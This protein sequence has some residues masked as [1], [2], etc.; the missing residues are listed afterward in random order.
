[1][2]ARANGI[3]LNLNSMFLLVF[4]LRYT[5]TFLRKM[6][7]IY[8]LP[9]DQH[10]YFHKFAGILIFVQGWFHGIMH[11]INFGIKSLLCTY[12]NIDCTTFCKVFL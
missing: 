10:L 9:L 11:F 5:I 12:Y 7:L 6:G 3:V 2:L 8:V 1:M 4:V